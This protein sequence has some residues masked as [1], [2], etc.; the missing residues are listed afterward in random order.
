MRFFVLSL[1][2]AAGTFAADPR[3]ELLD[4]DRAFARDTAARGLDGWMSWFAEDAQLNHR[5]GVIKGKPALRAHYGKVIGQP[6]VAVTWKPLY[7]EASQDA[8]L[9]YT[10]GEAEWTTTGKDGK[11]EKS[12][13]HYL[14]VWRKMKDGS[15]KVVT[16]LGS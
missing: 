9:G 7:A 14:T 12:V 6:G 2:L 4:A 16:D 5:T 11:V 3:A 15:W 1:L 13:G 8:T 10:V